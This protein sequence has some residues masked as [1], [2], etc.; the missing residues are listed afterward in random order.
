MNKKDGLVTIPK[1]ELD[2]LISQNKQLIKQNRD[3]QKAL[4]TLIERG[5][6]DG[7]DR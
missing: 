3:L 5:T 7:N 6:N 2:F 1:K 4:C